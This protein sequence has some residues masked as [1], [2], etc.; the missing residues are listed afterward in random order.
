MPIRG[1]TLR[2]AAQACCDHVNRVLCTT[3]TETRLVL[4]AVRG[5]PLVQLAFRQTGRPTEAL[6]QTRFGPM[7]LY[8]GQTCGS[9]RGPDGLHELRTVEYRY[10]LTP[11]GSGEPLLR[12]EYVGAPAPEDRWCR[13]H[14]QGPVELRVPGHAVSLNDLHLPTGYVPF[15]EILS[16]CIVDLGVSPLSDD[17]DRTLRESYTRFKSV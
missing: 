14:L 5:A 17:W 11:E 13:H 2:E 9:A 16:F 4:V 10:T 12:W 1:R 15:E 8:M 7:R 3:V 6:L